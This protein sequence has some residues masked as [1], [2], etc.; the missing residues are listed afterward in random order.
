MISLPDGKMKSRTGNVVDADTLADDMHKQSAAL[1]RERY[2]DLSD[3]EITAKAETI[4]LAAI[5][6]FMLK[7]DVA[8]EFVFDSAQSLSFDGET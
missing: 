1:L 4:A 3:E 2:T 6:F 7:Y 5:K 8:K